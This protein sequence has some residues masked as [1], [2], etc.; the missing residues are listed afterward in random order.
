MYGCSAGTFEGGLFIVLRARQVGFAEPVAGVGAVGAHHR[1]GKDHGAVAGEAADMVRMHVGQ[2]DLIDLGGLIA[3]GLQ[4]LGKPAQRRA[5]QA[6]GAR[7][8]QHQLVAGID[9]VGIDRSVNRT[10]QAGPDQRP[11]DPGRRG[12]GQQLVDRQ[13]HGPVRQ[14][15]DFKVAE[16]HAVIARR[17]GPD[18]G[19]GGVDSACAANQGSK[20]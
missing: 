20:R 7:I 11:V 12:I 9:Q 17:L 14:R 16:H 8:Y 10:G 4:V 5:E 18:H 13:R 1:I 15:G 6:G 3:G 2:V 19:G